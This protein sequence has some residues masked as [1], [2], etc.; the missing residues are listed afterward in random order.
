MNE[1]IHNPPVSHPPLNSNVPYHPVT[2]NQI[3][4]HEQRLSQGITHNH[5][6]PNNFQHAHETFG[7]RETH[8]GNYN[9][10]RNS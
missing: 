5:W 8:I 4:E 10:Q 3:H 1:N 7:H 9:Q 6:N 2:S